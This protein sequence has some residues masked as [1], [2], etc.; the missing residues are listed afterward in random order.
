[1]EYD[2]TSIA[3]FARR[4]TDIWN[5]PD[6]VARR[7]AVSELWAEDGVEWTGS[8][9]YRGHAAIQARV[10]AAYEEFVRD[11]GFRFVPAD[12]AVGHEGGITFTTH[13][14]PATGGAPVWT[15]TV[16][17]LLDGDG[18]IHSDHQFVRALRD[19]GTRATAE[20]FVRRLG[21]RDPEGLAELFAE[22][23]DFQ[24]DWPAD[25]HPAVP[26][27]RPRSTRAD[28]ADLFRELRDTH[29][30]QEGEGRAPTLLVDG[31]DAVVLGEIRQTVRATGV[32]YTAGYALRLTVDDGLITAYH[33]Y[34]D[35]LSVADAL[36]ATA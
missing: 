31:A 23:V 11:G 20:E 32:S 24:L 28:M 10:T 9:K 7:A 21:S 29:V 25:G 18:R 1:M 3:A 5:E 19:T 30:P 12:D 4:Y 26:W 22:K 15:G 17:A 34:E 6:P 2:E 8:T 36:T 35:S 27:I 16:F 14:I 13:M 33:V